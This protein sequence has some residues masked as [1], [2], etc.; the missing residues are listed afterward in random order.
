MHKYKFFKRPI[1]TD[2]HSLFTCLSRSASCVLHNILLCMPE[3]ACIC[4][5][6]F[7][8]CM[9]LF[10]VLML[11][12]GHDNTRKCMCMLCMT[13]SSELARG[14]SYNFTVY[15]PVVKGKCEDL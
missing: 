10:Q 14:G 9:T 4:A 12:V 13:P 15:N 8:W 6:A 2:S 11:T 5:C 3:F 1:L 7:V